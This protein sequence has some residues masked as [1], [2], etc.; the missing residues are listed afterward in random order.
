MMDLGLRSYNGQPQFQVIA[1]WAMPDAYAEQDPEPMP[2]Q[3]TPSQPVVPPPVKFTED[4][5]PF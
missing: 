2:A 1:A 3:S 4:D 5:I